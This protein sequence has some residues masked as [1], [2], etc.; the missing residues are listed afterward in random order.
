MTIGTAQKISVIIPAYNEQ[1]SIPILLE[2]CATRFQQSGL[3]GQVIVINDGS[4]DL[5]GQKLA[6]AKKQYPFLSIVDHQANRGITAALESGFAKA[7][8]DIFIYYPAD[9][10]Y[11]PADIPQLVAKM[12]EGYD[13]VTGWR[14]GRYGGKK[15][16]SA[17]Y[18][19]LSRLFFNVS[20]H[21][22]NSVKAFRRE[23]FSTIPLQADWH[24]Y[25]VVLAASQGYRVAEVRIPLYPRRYGQSKFGPNRVVRAFWD[26]VVV[27]FFVKYSQKPMV[28]FGNAGLACSLIGVAILIYLAVLH[29]QGQKIGDRPLL[30]IS[31]LII[32]VGLQLF[33]LGILGELINQQMRRKK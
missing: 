9:L 15:I 22:L 21:D 33:A 11:S 24:R 27:V 19:F 13:M 17:V 1:E 32:F 26:F 18:N 5:T 4:A 6:E 29:F 25:M 8:G 10:Q 20:V 2:Q 28:L 16:V 23:I 3:T 7:E 14:Q 12:N 31:I 30:F